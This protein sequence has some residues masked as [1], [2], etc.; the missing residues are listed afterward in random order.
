MGNCHELIAGVLHVQLHHF[1]MVC[2]NCLLRLK[3]KE[4]LLLCL[5]NIRHPLVVVGRVQKGLDHVLR[6][7]RIQNLRTLLLGIVG[8]LTL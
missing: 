1:K 3:V 2:M 6:L 7:E 4:R 5:L 8:K